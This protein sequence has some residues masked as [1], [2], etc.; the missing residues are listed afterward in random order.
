MENMFNCL[1][2]LLGEPEVK[3]AFIEAEGTEL[4]IIMIK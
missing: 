3:T 1:C 4:M 2:S